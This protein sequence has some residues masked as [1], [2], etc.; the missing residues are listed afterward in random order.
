M[1]ESV[2]N[3]SSFPFFSIRGPCRARPGPT[4]VLDGFFTTPR[5][6]FGCPELEDAE[7][8]ITVCVFPHETAG[9]A[10]K[11]GDVISPLVEENDPASQFSNL[12]SLATKPEE[13]GFLLYEKMYESG[14]R[15][16][17]RWIDEQ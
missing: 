5:D 2:C 17:M 15:D 10:S 4:L 16:A 7:R 14:R 12:I 3:S 9:L 8:T 1:G 6:R 11:E 13:D